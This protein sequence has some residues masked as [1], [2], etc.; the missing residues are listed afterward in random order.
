[1]QFDESDRRLAQ[2][3]L[4]TVRFVTVSEIMR[5]IGLK[6]ERY[7]HSGTVQEK[8]A[9]VPVFSEEDFTP[10]FVGPFRE[11]GPA[12]FREFNPCQNLSAAPGSE[13]LVANL[14]RGVGRR[15]PEG[16]T[17]VPAFD[18]DDLREHQVR[19]V[20][21]VTDFIG[22]GQQVVDYVNAWYRNATIKS[23]HSYRKIRFDVLA[24]SATASG[25]A[26]V[27]NNPRVREV[28]VVEMAPSLDSP[29]LDSERTNIENLCRIYRKRGR[30]KDKP[31]GY[32][33]S[34]ALFAS[35]ISVP[36]NLPPILRCRSSRWRPFFEGRSVS[37]ALATEL[38]SRVIGSL[39]RTVDNSRKTDLDNVR[40]R[41][42]LPRLDWRPHLEVLQQGGL[43]NEELAEQLGRPV[44]AVSASR[45]FLLGLGLICPNGQATDAG[46]DALKAGNRRPRQISA[47]LHGSL[48]PYYPDLR[49]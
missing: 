13:A 30:L 44:D 37:P 25:L 1:M 31:L 41:S 46:I 49:R 42:G 16:S 26:R 11:E 45:K 10:L 7:T 20:V 19:T 24:Y 34:G 23:W 47:G 35:E 43:T 15:Q 29:L 21:C 8:L 40:A 48:S 5:A 17:V 33:S 3:L 27:K 18:L 22:S 4:D 6:L 36:N 32:A 38:A 39:P 14:I 2:I 12:M 28:S 9:I